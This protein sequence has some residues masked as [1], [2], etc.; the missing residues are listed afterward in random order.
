MPVFNE[1]VASWLENGTII[2]A[3]S[4]PWNHPIT[5]APKKDNDGNKTGFRPCLDP[6]N[7]NKLLPSDNQ[8]IP[9]IQGI[10]SDIG[11]SDIFSTLDL[12]QAYHR[13][14]IYEPH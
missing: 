4:T 2:P 9:L 10:F 5:F 12:R 14:P 7:L 6:R 1:A 13:L 11:G 3:T 8:P